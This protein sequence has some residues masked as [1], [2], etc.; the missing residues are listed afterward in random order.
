[1]G[2]FTLS[3]Y[4]LRTRLQCTVS[5]TS[6]LSAASEEIGRVRRPRLIP[7]ADSC[8]VEK[9]R[10]GGDQLRS[11]AQKDRSCSST[12]AAARGSAW[13]GKTSA[14][15]A[16]R[17]SAYQRPIPGNGKTGEPARSVATGRRPDCAKAWPGCFRCAKCASGGAAAGK[18]WRRRAACGF[19][20]APRF[21]YA[22][23]CAR[24]S[25]QCRAFRGGRTAAGAW[26]YATKS[27]KGG[28]GCGGT[29]SAAFGSA[30]ERH[31]CRLCG[32]EKFQAHRAA[33]P[34]CGA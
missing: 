26:V 8:L 28:V 16:S 27:R 15:L 33:Q 24:R 23:C 32:I 29:L 20:C 5:S 19:G 25:G 14:D 13:H 17:R 2:A 9:W 11:T 10:C 30:G 6:S 7:F 12:T 21:G 3:P 4:L 1:V 22:G 18:R 31:R 34:A